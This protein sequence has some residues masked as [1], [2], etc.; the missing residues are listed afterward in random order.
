SVPS[1]V[2]TEH[3]PTFMAKALRRVA[4]NNPPPLVSPP[5]PPPVGCIGTFEQGDICTVAVSFTPTKPRQ[6][7]VQLTVTDTT[8]VNTPI[9]LTGIGVGSL[10][11]ITPGIIN[12]P[13]GGDNAT[14]PAGIV[15]DN[16]GNTFA[17]DYQ[18]HVVRKITAQGTVSV[19][20]GVE[21]E[22]GYDGDGSAA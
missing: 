21:D 15:R 6:R 22:E 19:V 9:A 12:T 17:A 11:S 5:E 20:A 3:M 1:E 14:S 16:F 10:V 2:K 4:G 7:C 8:Q 13:A 18:R